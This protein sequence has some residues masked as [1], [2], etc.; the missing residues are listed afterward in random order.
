MNMVGEVGKGPV[1]A[2]WC[3]GVGQLSGGHATFGQGPGCGDG[4][5]GREEMIWEGSE[6]GR[7]SQGVPG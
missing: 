1:W 5:G 4:A 7:G 6:V 3:R 2:A